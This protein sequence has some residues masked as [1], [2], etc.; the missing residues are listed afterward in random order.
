MGAGACADAPLAWVQGHLAQLGSRGRVQRGSATT[1]IGGFG[2]LV[3]CP[4]GAAGAAALILV[5]QPEARVA[6][7]P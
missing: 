5:T 1:V 6:Q 3:R 7:S 4:G 2:V